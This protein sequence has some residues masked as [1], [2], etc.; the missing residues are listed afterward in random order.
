VEIADDIERGGFD[1]VHLFWSR[2]PGLVLALLKRRGFAGIRSAFAGAYDLV[3]DDFLT[4]LSLR[5]ASIAFSHADANRDFI[6]NRVNPETR[7]EIIHRGIPLPEL[8]DAERN[9]NL[10]L[11]ASALVKE[12]NV[13]GVLRAFLVARADEPELRLSVCGDGPDRAR[14]EQLCS[15]LGCANVV[16]FEGHIAREDLALHMAKADT[17]LLL[18]KK[19]SE[20]LP[21]VV[22]EALWAGCEVIS[23]NSTGIREVLPDDSFGHVV[24]PDDLQA[25]HAV[26]RKVVTRDREGDRVR[27]AKARA[28]ICEKFSAATNMRRYV[29]AWTEALGR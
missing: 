5:S 24:D 17:F 1:V 25:V 6:E 13:E 9:P 22:K 15:K 20:R 7:V 14:L 23:S 4:L 16:A 21:N 29:A 2:H 27:Q 3:A 11:S 28:L 26:V 12:K 18:S 8:E 10:W 19:P